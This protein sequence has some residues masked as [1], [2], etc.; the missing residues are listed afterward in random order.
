[1]ITL[2]LLNLAFF[3]DT[4]III[5]IIMR[6]N[7]LT[8]FPKILFNIYVITIVDFYYCY[9]YRAVGTGQAGQAMA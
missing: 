8:T 4:I 9:C 6:K 7:C 3:S 2:I 1:M 5:I